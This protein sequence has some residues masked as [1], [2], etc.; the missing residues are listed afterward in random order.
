MATSGEAMAAAGHVAHVLPASPEVAT[1]L[2]HAG[3][4]FRRAYEN[5]ARAATA[6]DAHAA[7]EESPA[8]LANVLRAGAA[9][10]GIGIARARLPSGDGTVYLTE[11]LVE[12]TD[13]GAESP[14]TPDAR[15][16]EALWA[17]RAR[18]GLPPHTS[19][20]AL[21]ALARD[22]AATMARR[23][24]PAPGDVVDRALAEHR[25]QLAAADVFVAGGPDDATR[26]A[27][28]KDA[29]FS[30]VGVGVV[31]GDSARYGKARLW[32]AVIYTD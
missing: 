25:R 9:R 31:T 24:E 21:D 17:E 4:P 19:H 10:A 8:H 26:S 16:R 29:R 1:R 27:N 13:D 28:V 30:R 2:R 12:P 3:V 20:P 32:I 7:V 14:L 11:V 6:L 22:S 23:D 5:V 18:L 15:I